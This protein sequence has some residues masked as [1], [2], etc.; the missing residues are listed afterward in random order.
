MEIRIATLE[1]QHHISQIYYQAF[2]EDEREIVSYLA[3]A[4]LRTKTS[5]PILSIVAELDRVLIGHIA[6]SPVWLKKPS[7]QHFL[8]YILAP[9]AVMP[10]YQRQSVG[11]TLV[12]NGLKQLE[13]LN[14]TRVF[15]YGDPNYYGRFG[16][17]ADLATHF[18]PPY[19]LQYP[20]GWLGTVLKKENCLEHAGAIECVAPLC[21]P[22]LW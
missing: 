9:L 1:D 21:D 19:P 13:T 22:K 4:L 20:Y 11:S 12:T 2:P 18:P 15:V 7:S 3:I 14:T 6:F 5:S 10:K 8:G 16:F 17:N